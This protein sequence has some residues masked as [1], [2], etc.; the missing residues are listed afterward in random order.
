CPAC[1]AA[2]TSVA[3]AH[4][5]H[6]CVY[7]G[8]RYQLT[9]GA[10]RTLV[11]GGA[12]GSSTNLVAAL[13][14]G[15]LLF[16]LLG[17]AAYVVLARAEDAP[18]APVPTPPQTPSTP[19]PAPVPPPLPAPLPAPA[20]V[21]VPPPTAP[22]AP[23][24]I[25]FDAPPDV[26]PSASFEMHSR[27]RSGGALWI[28]GFVTNTSPLPL[29][30]VKVTAVLH[31]AK[32]EEIAQ[33]SGY[34]EWDVLAPDE[35]SP[36]VMLV[37]DP[38]AFD[39]ITFETHADAPFYLPTLVAGLEL[40]GKEPHKDAFLGYKATGKVHHRGD[41]PARFVRVDALGYDKD[42]K[43]IGTAFAYADVDVLAPGASARYSLNFFDSTK[44]K[45]FEFFVHA[46][47]AE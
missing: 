7:C 35:R 10:P 17:A 33:D 6:T 47:P 11:A 5:I 29:G 16:G 14:G 26:A 8:A 30:K 3:D 34:S 24:G 37:S 25:S 45:R 43:L 18:S 40:E 2:D 4:G 12:K 20:P 9:R 41:A 38:P 31:D 27:R 36:I 39:S 42:D 15:L 19:A 32:G 46:Q 1:G 23:A 22:A 44:Y 21:A 13:V 28:Y